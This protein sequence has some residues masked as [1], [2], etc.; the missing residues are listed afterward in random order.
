MKNE[1]DGIIYDA[2]QTIKKMDKMSD[3]QKLQMDANR[4]REFGQNP[5]F[6]SVG[7]I[8]IGPLCTK[9]TLHELISSNAQP[10]T[11]VHI[12]TW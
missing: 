4:H 1:I 7:K 3:F 9:E 2:E 6:K 12:E 5:M 10:H 11:V 8:T